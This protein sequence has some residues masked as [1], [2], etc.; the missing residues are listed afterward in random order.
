M[1]PTPH[2]PP[3]QRIAALTHRAVAQPSLGL[4]MYVARYVALCLALSLGL[5]ACQQ[6]P[7]RNACPTGQDLTP[8]MLNGQWT[9][10]I[11]GEAPWTLTL[12]PHP[13]HAGSLRGELTQ[14]QQRHAVVADLDDGEFTLE[15]THDGQRIAATWL[16]SVTAS[17]CGRQI[18]G[19]RALMG[20]SSRDFLI[21]RTP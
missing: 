2:S 1:T 12:G 21:S 8:E 13:E 3:S 15:E 6:L 17:S 14:G 4:A 5:S 11:A 7:T 18:Q 16:G 10:Q 19:Q 20:Q 9:A